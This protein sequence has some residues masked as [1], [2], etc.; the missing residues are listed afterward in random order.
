MSEHSMDPKPGSYFPFAN[1]ESVDENGHSP[2]FLMGFLSCLGTL[3]ALYVYS[4][5]QNHSLGIKTDGDKYYYLGTYGPSA[6][7]TIF[8]AAWTQAEYRAV[9][10]MPWALMLRGP[11]PASQ[12]I[13]LD[14]LLKLNIVSLYQSLKQRRFLVSLCVAGSLILNGVTVFSTGLFELDS[15]LFNHPAKLT[16]P[17]KFSEADYDPDMI[18]TKSIVSGVEFSAHN[19]RLALLPPLD[20]GFIN[21][22]IPALR[23]QLTCAPDPTNGDSNPPSSN[24]PSNCSTHAMM[25]GKKDKE[26]GYRGAPSIYHDIYCN[27]TIEEVE[28]NTKLQLPSLLIDFDTP[29]RVFEGSARIPFK[30]NKES[31]P[32]ILRLS[33]Y[34]FVSDPRFKDSFLD[35]IT[36]G[37]NGVPLDEL[38]DPEKLINRV[39]EVWGIIMA[40]LLHTAARDSFD[41]PFETTYFVEPATMKAPTYSGI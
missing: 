2:L 31:L 5:Q 14:Y 16:V 20:T 11:T 35:A 30:T 26:N 6:V 7:F 13:F 15:V 40:Q 22:R 38:L 4:E 18:H 32:A 17:R 23:S 29:P 28:V 1:E 24:V 19:F 21:A 39:N 25:Y 8:T 12:S 37:I 36:N 33:S 3:I 10:L 41:D 34:L 9:Q 27:A